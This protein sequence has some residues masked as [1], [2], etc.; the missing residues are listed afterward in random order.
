MIVR[1]GEMSRIICNQPSASTSS[2]IGLSEPISSLTAISLSLVRQSGVEIDTTFEMLLCIKI[3]TFLQLT[4]FGLLSFVERQAV[5]FRPPPGQIISVWGFS[6]VPLQAVAGMRFVIAEQYL[7][8]ITFPT[9]APIVHFHFWVAAEIEKKNS[10]L[11]PQDFLKTFLL[12][13]NSRGSRFWFTSSVA[14]CVWSCCFGLHYFFMLV[15]WSECFCLSKWV[16]NNSRELDPFFLPRYQPGSTQRW[17]NHLG[18]LP[19]L[20]IL[21]FI[22]NLK[23]MICPIYRTI[24]SDLWRWLSNKLVV[25]Y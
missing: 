13:F 16:K 20:F 7:Q 6:S 8:F 9:T 24:Q 10:M 14:V 1:F 5:H 11:S 18:Y 22:T 21:I 17:E 23:K 3:P 2:V 19:L 25:V 15:I 4:K 12:P